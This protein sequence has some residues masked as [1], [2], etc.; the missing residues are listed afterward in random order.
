MSSRPGWAATLFI[1][2]LSSL[3]LATECRA[4]LVNVTI[5]DSL[6]DPVTGAVF[7]YS[8]EGG[9]LDGREPCNGCTTRPDPALLHN[10]TWHDSTFNPRVGGAG[11]P[12]NTPRF[13]SVKFTGTAIYVYCV[14]ART[15]SGPTGFSDMTFFIDA[16]PGYDY[17]VLVYHNTSL[18]P[19]EHEFILQ[20]GNIDGP[21]A[22]TLF[23]RIVYTYDNGLK[24]EA[25]RKS[26]LAAILGGTLGG[27]AVLC[28]LAVGFAIWF[29]Q[30]RKRSRRKTQPP[31]LLLDTSDWVN[32]P[33]HHH[34]RLGEPGPPST[35]YHSSSLAGAHVMTA[36]NVG[37]GAPTNGASGEP[38]SYYNDWMQPM[39]VASKG[40]YGSGVMNRI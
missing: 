19:G 24:T 25:Q 21:K 13:A 40:R 12:P 15:I 36:V 38:P 7:R 35:T 37:T 34:D 32:P 28:I 20:N 10:R 33:P 8:P 18:P 4:F 39:T 3:A 6:P 30:I 9:W 23:D 26:E 2:F 22:L 31:N 29:F 16:Q 14:L 17:D 5:D 1:V 11:F 27:L